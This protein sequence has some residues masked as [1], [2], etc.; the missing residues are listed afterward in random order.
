MRGGAHRRVAATPSG[1]RRVDGVED[2]AMIQHERAVYFDF[3]TG[4]DRVKARD[5]HADNK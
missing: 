5:H 2:G 1:R 3:H 4:V